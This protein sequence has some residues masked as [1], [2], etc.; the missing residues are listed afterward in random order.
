MMQSGAGPGSR[1][2]AMRHRHRGQRCVI[3]ANGPSLNR[4]TLGFLRAEQVIGMNKIFLGLEDF[5]FYPRYYVAINPKVLRQSGAEIRALN[6][7]RF[8]GARA[9]RAV[10]LEEDALTH[11]VDTDYIS[12]RFSSDLSL[13]LHEGF[14]VTHAALQVAYHLGYEEVVLIGMDHRYAFQGAPN[15]ARVMQGADPNHFSDRYFGYGLIWDN[16][17]L[18]QSEISYQAALEAFR[19]DGRRV[20]DATVDGACTVFPKID[21]RAHFAV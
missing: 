4:M 8:L 12:T 3:V 16:P 9:A 7:V 15:E 20:L 14:T 6:C 19:R 17:D 2:K 13:G 10:G 1:L 21:Y 18:Q 11:H 5:G